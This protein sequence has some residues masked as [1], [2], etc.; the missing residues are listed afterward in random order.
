[1]RVRKQSPNYDLKMIQFVPDYHEFIRKFLKQSAKNYGVKSFRVSKSFLEAMRLKA[2]PLRAEHRRI[3]S[4]VDT[5]AEIVLLL[6]D[7]TSSDLCLEIKVS[8]MVL[9][10]S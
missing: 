1:M 9:I 6:P 2:L 8:S 3:K 10:F 4:D 7:L 5:E